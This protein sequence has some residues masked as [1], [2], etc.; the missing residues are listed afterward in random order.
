MPQKA[1]VT[2]LEA[3][4]TFRANLIVYL[5]QARPALDEVSADVMRARAWL[6]D[7]Q[8]V[9]WENQMR[10]RTKELE[11]AQQALFSAR[12]GV[13]RK[14][15]SA[16]QFAV[17]RAKAAVT[18]ADEKLRTIK[19][20]S[21]DFEGRVQPLVK[22]TEKLHTVFSNDMVQA[23]AYLTQ[24]IRTLAAYAEIKA[25]ERGSTGAA[26]MPMTSGGEGSSEAQAG[27]LPAE[28]PERGN[29]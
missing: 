19:R 24:V 26:P 22:Q 15:T 27:H 17:H 3:L 4:E 2:S 1:R 23:I 6:E 13:L 21:R 11:Q 8:R 28:T 9:H 12:L 18:Q 29:L 5:S 14:E 25:P 10:R 16:E 7:E 20:W